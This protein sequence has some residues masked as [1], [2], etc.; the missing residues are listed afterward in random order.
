MRQVSANIA[1]SVA[2]YSDDLGAMDSDNLAAAAVETE[3]RWEA[4]EACFGPAAMPDAAAAAKAD[5]GG[6]AEPFGDCD[7]CGVCLAPL[8]R[9]NPVAPSTVAFAGRDYHTCCA[10]FYSN[11]V[12]RQLPALTSLFV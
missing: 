4:A 7:G 12:E 3:R 1:A 5:G 9:T 8:S 10:N 2:Y 6:G 11:R